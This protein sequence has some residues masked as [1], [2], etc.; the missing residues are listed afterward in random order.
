L[1]EAHLL[2]EGLGTLLRRRVK[3]ALGEL[4]EP[5]STETEVMA[6]GKADQLLEAD[7]LDA[8]HLFFD[9]L[10]M[11]DRAHKGDQAWRNDG[12]RPCGDHAGGGPDHADFAEDSEKKREQTK[13]LL[14]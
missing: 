14:I 6:V 13:K 7:P 8:S 10:W 2:A 5:D 3:E 11:I 1:L 4:R 12:R 9:E